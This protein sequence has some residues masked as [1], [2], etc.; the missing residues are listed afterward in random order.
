[1]A[2]TNIDGKQCIWQENKA[3]KKALESSDHLQIGPWPEVQTI[4]LMRPRADPIRFEY[5]N[6][7]VSC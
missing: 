4:N 6:P 1:M 3:K 2:E 7:M 5:L